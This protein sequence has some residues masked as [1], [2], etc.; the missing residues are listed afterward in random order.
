MWRAVMGLVPWWAW[1]LVGAVV[2]ALV[3]AKADQNGADRVQAFWDKDKLLRQDAEQQRMRED[4]RIADQ[5][6]ATH[7]ADKA[8]LQAAIYRTKGALDAALKKPA[9]CGATAADVVIPGD[10]GMQLNA[11]EHAVGPAG[12]A[13]QPDD[14]V[15]P[16]PELP[17]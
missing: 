10:L 9:R 5:A 3:V 15:R 13:S 6:A 8:A 1:A 17:G 4:A 2:L 12:P 7:E 14:A 16:G 11:I